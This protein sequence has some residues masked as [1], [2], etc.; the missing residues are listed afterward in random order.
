MTL[1][2]EVITIFPELFDAHLR[3]SLLGKAIANGLLGVRVHDLRG[4]GIGK[5]RSI[6]DEPYGGG[7]GMVM[8]PEPIF[9]AVE[10]CAEADA[11]IVLL[12]PRGRRLDQRE[13]ERLATKKQ[14]ILICGRYEGVDERVAMHLAHEE[15]SIGDYV[16]AGGELAA[17]VVIEAVSRLVP[18][19]VGNR[20]S[21]DFESHAHG[22]EYPQY[23]RPP[24]FRGWRVPQVLLSGDHGTIEKWRREQADEITRARRPDLLSEG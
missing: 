15:I 7:A 20:E 12:S 1:R 13:V 5:H 19:V 3:T 16:L 10:H 23:T 17:L 2:I 9:E 11:H 21:L 18:G 8:R 14:V 22:L 6:D 24:E 4:F